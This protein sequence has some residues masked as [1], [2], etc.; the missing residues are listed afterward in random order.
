MEIFC[1]LC[2]KLKTLIYEAKEKCS[3]KQISDC[4][5][6]QR[7]LFGIVNHLLGHE[8]Q[9]AYPQHTDSFTLASLFNNYFITKIADIRKEF[10]GLESD[11]VQMSMPDFNVHHSHTTLSNFTPTTTDE[12]QQLLSKMNK[13]TC[14]LD[15]FCTSI[16]M[17]HSH[18]ILVYVHLINLCFST[19]IFPT[20]FKSAVVKPLL[21]KPTLD[22]EVLKNFRPISNLTFVSKLIEKVIAERLVS[23]MQDNGMVEKFQS[24]YKAN[25]STETA[26]L[27]VYNDMLFSIDQGG[28]G[29]LVL[30]DLSSAFDTIDHA[31]L[32]NL[33]Q[34]IF[35]ISGSALDLLKSYLDGRTQCVQIDGI[36]SEY[37]KLVCGVPQGSVLGPLS[38]CAYIRHE[39][40]PEFSGIP[41]FSRPQRSFSWKS[42]IRFNINGGGGGYHILCVLADRQQCWNG[43]TYI[44]I[45]NLF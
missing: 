30:L 2:F 11:V 21:K 7:Q 23:H 44:F 16:I 22:Y 40:F 12:V 3:K 9:I 20:G 45:I 35:E 42:Q 28:G 5:G 1:A 31:L 17:Q 13:T 37:A 29:I 32:F 15:P 36:V 41:E 19:G 38:F 6:D 14:K 39:I 10:S 27:R 4:G 24:A 18:F 34:D 33:W 25:H 8:K 43:T 26:L